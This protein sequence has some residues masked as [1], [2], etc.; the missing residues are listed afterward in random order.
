MGS[1][2]FCILRKLAIF[3]SWILDVFGNHIFW[4]C[5]K[6]KKKKDD[7]GFSL[8]NEQIV[9]FQIFMASPKKRKKVFNRTTDR[10]QISKVTFWL[11]LTFFGNFGNDPKIK[12]KTWLEEWL[13]VI[14]DIQNFLFVFWIGHKLELLLFLVL[15][16]VGMCNFG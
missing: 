16:K 13:H 15:L 1:T 11:N 6:G 8:Q 5:K 2:L 12:P 7:E 3:S 4:Q 14:I 9:V 10:R